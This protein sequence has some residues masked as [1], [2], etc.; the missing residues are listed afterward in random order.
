MWRPFCQLK[1]LFVK[2][3]GF[4]F[5]FTAFEKEPKLSSGDIFSGSAVSV[6]I[7]HKNKTLLVSADAFGNSV[8]FLNGEKTT[9]P[10]KIEKA[11]LGG[12]QQGDYFNVLIKLPLS[13]LKKSL[14]LSSLCE[15]ERLSMNAFYTILE[16]DKGYPTHYASLFHNTKE[17]EPKCALLDRENTGNVSAVLFD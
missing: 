8:C 2:K 5:S 12:D 14:G 17:V 7:K 3:D 9:L 6:S 16:N 15:S 4:Y 10:I 13:V 1:S 11:V